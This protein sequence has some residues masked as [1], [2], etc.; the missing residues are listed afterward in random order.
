MRA[1]NTIVALENQDEGK[2]STHCVNLGSN[3]VI[4]FGGD[5]FCFLKIL[6]SHE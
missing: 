2:C 6:S 1:W 3:L 4:F 5:L